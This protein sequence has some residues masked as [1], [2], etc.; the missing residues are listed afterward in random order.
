M[1]D[2]RSGSWWKIQAEEQEAALS[3]EVLELPSWSGSSQ[4]SYLRASLMTIESPSDAWA[5]TAPV[6]RRR[7][8]GLR[9][10][11]PSGLPS[12]RRIGLLCSPALSRLRSSHH[13]SGRV[14]GEASHPRPSDGQQ[15]R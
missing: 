5:D 9:C 3:R 7:A 13:T 15:A 11:S 6:L 1:P 12:P 2:E 8:D 4:P 10:S 14:R